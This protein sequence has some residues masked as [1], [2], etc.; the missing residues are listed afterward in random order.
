CPRREPA[1]GAELV[2]RSPWPGSMEPSATRG[3]VRSARAPGV[4]QVAR[5]APGAHR[6]QVETQGEAGEVGT[7]QQEQLGGAHG[8][9]ALALAER[10]ERLLEIGARLDLD[11][12]EQTAAPGDQ[13]DLA[14]RSA[15]A[16]GED[17]VAAQAQAPGGEALGPTP[18]GLAR[19]TVRRPFPAARCIGPLIGAAVHH[20]SSA[21][22]S[23]GPLPVAA[24]HRYVPGAVV[25]RPFACAAVH[26]LCSASA[27]RYSSRRDRP[28]AAATVAA[29]AAGDCRSSASARSASS[30]SPLG[31]SVVPAGGPTTITGSPRGGPLAA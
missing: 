21:A 16:P 25:H 7:A 24:V 9:L 12:G 15:K 22:R 30:S 5:Q 19:T 11:E 26:R 6:D 18:P 2:E 10:G 17:A 8:A 27:R 23:I 1:R 29:A 13:V 20:P 3:T 14:E 4:A 28:V 31:G